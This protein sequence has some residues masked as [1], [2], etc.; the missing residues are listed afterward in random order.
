MRKIEP[1]PSFRDVSIRGNGERLF[2]LALKSDFNEII[3]TVNEKYYYWDKV[4]HLRV[5]ADIKPEEVW[6]TAKLRRVN[7]PFKISFGNHSFSWFLNSHIQE[8]LHLFDLNIGGSLESRSVIPSEDRDRY[9]ISS[10]MEEAIASSQ[11]EGA[12]TTR[13]QAKEMLRKNKIP[14]TKDERMI[15]NN[16]VTIQQILE[17]KDQHITVDKILQIHKLV[18]ADTLSS[19]E[20]E[21]NF[22]NSNDVNVVDVVDG[23]I[24]YSPPDFNEID[25][26]IDELCI[27]FNSQSDKTFIH[28]IIKGCI[29][30]FMIGYIH[31]FADGNG[32]TARALF[33]WYLLKRGYWLTEYLSISKLILR[34]KAQYARA[35][36]YTEIDDH[37]LTYFI[38]YNL[39][40]MNLA[41]EA[42]R[43]YIQRKIEEKRQIAKF[44]RLKSI[45]E[46][47][48]LILKWIY[49][50]ENLILTVKEVE[51]RLVISN[52][53][54]R[55]DLQKLV[56]LG[57]LEALKLDLKTE[58]FIKGDKFDTLIQPASKIIQ[59]DLFDPD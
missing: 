12:V 22:R 7:S 57:Y 48:A 58:A 21:G 32:R 19:R 26:L 20:E 52:Q 49:E 39:R 55:T 10:I 53:T 45:N 37:D 41:F 14:K 27:F 23:E 33:Y 38:K 5:P 28:P 6:L 13:K 4:K 50:D 24:V 3:N 59:S 17:V 16:Y 46:R 1:P 34:S 31:P 56:R 30:H 2:Q 8:L 42:L 11:I 25:L 43:D 35:F 15:Y 47:Q 9:L 40:T 51:T 29:I 54:A 44:I 18:T 36:Q